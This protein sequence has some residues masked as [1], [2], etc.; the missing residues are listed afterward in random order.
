[1]HAF[2]FLNKAIAVFNREFGKS[3]VYVC[4]CRVEEDIY[5]VVYKDI[6]DFV[7]VCVSDL[8]R[9]AWWKTPHSLSKDSIKAISKLK[10]ISYEDK[11]LV[12]DILG[13]E[14][15]ALHDI[16][17]PAHQFRWDCLSGEMVN[18]KDVLSQLCRMMDHKSFNPRSVG[19]PQLDQIFSTDGKVAVTN[20]HFLVQSSWDEEE[21]SIQRPAAKILHYGIKSQKVTPVFIN[22]IKEEK[23]AQIHC[24]L[25]GSPMILSTKAFLHEGPPISSLDDNFNPTGYTLIDA[26]KLL[27][28]I[29]RIG[30]TFSEDEVLGVN[31]SAIDN[32]ATHVNTHLV[33]K[34]GKRQLTSVK[35]GKFCDIDREFK[36]KS[37]DVMWS[38]NY[39]TLLMELDISEVWVTSD[40]APSV[41]FGKDNIEA[42]LMP[43]RI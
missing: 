43:K 37:R 12:A 8:N 42:L 21:V 31:L 5:I 34:Q 22:N 29:A 13:E 3:N 25:D 33:H 27:P 6:T 14:S 16:K 17:H 4:G 2:K 36:V 40:S 9:A 28:A 15:E 1:M 26:D 20:G 19:R 35:L 39:L 18:W 38:A 32:E 10:K 41:F 23:M 30:K 24:F 7:A 11:R